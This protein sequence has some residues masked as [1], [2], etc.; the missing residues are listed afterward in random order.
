MEFSERFR[1]AD[2]PNSKIPLVAAGVYAIWN[3]DDL[4]YCGMSGRQIEH[5][6]ASGKH[7]FGLITRLNSHASGRLSGDQFCVYVANRLVIPTLKHGDLH[8]FASGELR[9]D[10]LTKTFIH[11]YLDYQY[12]IVESSSE[13]YHVESRARR[14]EIFGKKPI[15]NPLD[16]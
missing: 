7:K 4:F 3:G 2:W 12:V 10:H 1:F 9:L 11:D 16:T 15:L 6:I 14:G 13:A 8:K 5:A